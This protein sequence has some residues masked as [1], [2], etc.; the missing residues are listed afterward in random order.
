MP[1]LG[2]QARD[3]IPFIYEDTT[4]FL[5]DVQDVTEQVTS[6]ALDWVAGMASSLGIA[7]EH[8]YEVLTRQ[9]VLEGWVTLLTSP[10]IIGTFLVLLFM[11]QRA[12]VALHK[13]EYTD[14]A[15][16]IARVFV[17]AVPG[18]VFLIAAAIL[19]FEAI[20]I[21]I[22][23]INNPEFYAIKTLLDAVSGSQ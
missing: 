2:V 13:A 18:L 20:P 21:A 16:A 3:G 15:V 6:R 12:I 22:M 9:M 11:F 4:M 5:Q 1:S 17:T 23:K 19:I 14:E 10:M 7:A 8:V